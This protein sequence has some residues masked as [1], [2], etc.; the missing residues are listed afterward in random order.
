LGLDEMKNKT[1]IPW[2]LFL[3]RAD[4]FYVLTRFSWF[5]FLQFMP[6]RIAHHTLEYYF[7]AGLALH[8]PSNELKTLGHNLEELCNEYQRYIPG[9][10]VDRR[11]IQ[12]LNAFEMMRYP[13]TSKY[14]RVAWGMSYAELF[15]RVVKGIPKQTQHTL[16][17]FSLN[18][19]DKLVFDLRSFL[20]HGRKLPFIFATKDADKY[21]FLEN[22][23]FKRDKEKSK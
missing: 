3:L 11:I 4:E 20:P 19:I 13:E 14:A 2:E 17:C 21:L 10:Q 9:Y 18:D 1:K 8:L 22:L 23:F 5:A 15:S 12:H 16:A 6:F 7:K